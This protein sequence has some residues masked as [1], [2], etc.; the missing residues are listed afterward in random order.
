MEGVLSAILQRETLMADCRRARSRS[1][2]T[3]APSKIR[4]RAFRQAHS[5]SLSTAAKHLS[6]NIVGRESTE[7]LATNCKGRDQVGVH[8]QQKCVNLTMMP[9]ELDDPVGK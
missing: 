2:T 5:Q 3:R 8:V 7:S 4:G 9:Q 1:P 6:Q